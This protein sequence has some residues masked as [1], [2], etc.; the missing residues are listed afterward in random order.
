MK[1]PTVPAEDKIHNRRN[2]QDTYGVARKI[3]IISCIE[4][5]AVLGLPILN[6]STIK[7]REKRQRNMMQV[8]HSCKYRPERRG[9]CSCAR[10]PG[11]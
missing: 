8:A 5:I 2:I 6:R 4:Q 3:N 7:I 9:A 11:S 10:G 1:H